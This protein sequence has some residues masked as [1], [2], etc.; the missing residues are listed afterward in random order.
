MPCTDV[1]L[2]SMA[3]NDKDARMQ[4]CAEAIVGSDCNLYRVAD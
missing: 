1:E 3:M 4:S 2:T